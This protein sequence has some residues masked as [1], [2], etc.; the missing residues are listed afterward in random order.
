MPKLEDNAIVIDSHG[1]RRYNRGKWYELSWTN[2][3][4]SEDDYEELGQIGDYETGQ[5][6]AE[7]IRQQQDPRHNQWGA[8]GEPSRDAYFENDFDDEEPIVSEVSNP[9]Q[10]ARPQSPN[11]S[12]IN[13][14]EPPSVL[15]TVNDDSAENSDSTLAQNT[16]NHRNSIN[17]SC[18]RISYDDLL[19]YEQY[20]EQ[21]LLPLRHSYY[22]QMH[23]FNIDEW[24]FYSAS[25]QGDCV[26]FTGLGLQRD[27]NRIYHRSS[28]T[29]PQH[30][31]KGAWRSVWLYKLQDIVDNSWSSPDT[32]HYVLTKPEDTRYVKY[33]FK[34]YND[35]TIVYNEQH[36]DQTVWYTNWNDL[37]N[38]EH[39][40]PYINS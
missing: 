5:Y 4:S 1:I 18:S 24:H 40:K 19:H 14:S 12:S 38:N 16:E 25:V 34:K 23:Q 21:S 22:E 13:S 35:R 30:M 31:G 39:V 36:I 29:L 3:A 37:I 27:L 33:G 9:T 15:D 32:V 6:S 28:L 20:Y 7:H 11:N 8:G 17:Y 26:A 10:N 2:Y